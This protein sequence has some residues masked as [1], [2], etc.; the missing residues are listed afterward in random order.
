L[1]GLHPKTPRGDEIRITEVS[2]HNIGIELLTGAMSVI[3]PKGT[4]LPCKLG[5]TY[6]TAED[7]Q[8][9]IA[10][11]VYEGNNEMVK[12]NILLSNSLAIRDLPA[13]PAGQAKM[14]VEF[15]IDLNGI[16]KMRATDLS[17][18]K[19]QISAVLDMAIQQAD[20]PTA[21]KLFRFRKPQDKQGARSEAEM[22]GEFSKEFLE[23]VDLSMRSVKVQMLRHNL[24]RFSSTSN[25]KA[26]LPPGSLQSII[27]AVSDAAKKVPAME[28]I[29]KTE[30][31]VFQ[32]ISQGVSQSQGKLKLPIWVKN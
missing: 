9:A 2:S 4:P 32:V 16:L 31:R 28:E 13:I 12:D 10:V 26:S 22:K 20:C 17:N 11:N 5:Q 25:V 14:S 21:A 30:K 7:N 1:L 18:E 27:A 29:E 23:R 6:N 15:E 24:E 19:N 3:I 8:R